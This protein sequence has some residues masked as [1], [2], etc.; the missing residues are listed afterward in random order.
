MTS[1]EAVHSQILTQAVDDYLN[2]IPDDDPLKA[3]LKADLQTTSVQDLLQH[4]KALERGFSNRSGYNR[5]LDRLSPAIEQF[6]RF[7]KVL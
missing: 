6:E 7:T 5:L 2:T 1:S 4:I 3:T